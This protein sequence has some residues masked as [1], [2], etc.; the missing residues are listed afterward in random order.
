M[1]EIG[2]ENLIISK[3]I[4]NVDFFEIGL[5]SLIV[6]KKI[7][8][9]MIRTNFGDFEPEKHEYRLNFVANRRKIIFF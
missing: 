9:D 4:I 5:R 7:N 1:V 2:I 6:E 3:K 8:F